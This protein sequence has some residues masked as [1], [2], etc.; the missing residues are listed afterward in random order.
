MIQQ[1]I[2][3]RNSYK[4]YIFFRSILSRIRKNSVQTLKLWWDRYHLRIELAELEDY[5]LKDIGITKSE[6][7]KEASKPFWK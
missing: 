5:Q 6:A 3:Q 2:T 7:Q 4:A 1:E